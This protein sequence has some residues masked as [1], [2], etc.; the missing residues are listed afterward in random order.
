MKPKFQRAADAAAKTLNAAQAV[1]SSLDGISLGPKQKSELAQFLESFCIELEQ[2]QTQLS[3]SDSDLDL[4]LLIARQLELEEAVRFLDRSFIEPRSNGSNIQILEAADWMCVEGYQLFV[5]ES[6]KYPCGPVVAIDASQSPAVWASSANLPIPSLFKTR[7]KHFDRNET[8]GEFPLICLPQHIARTPEYLPLLSHE[9]GHA[10]DNVL[11]LS[12]QVCSELEGKSNE[13]YW[14]AW[15]REIVGDSVGIALSGEAFGIA[16]RNFLRLQ[17]PFDELAHDHPYPPFE[18]RLKFIAVQLD[19]L[20]NGDLKQDWNLDPAPL[21]RLS[22]LAVELFVQFKQNVV[23]CLDQLIFQRFQSWREDNQTI[24]ELSVALK[25]DSSSAAAPNEMPFRLLPSAVCMAKFT[26][27]P[28][29]EF[30]SREAFRS[31]HGA[32]S[33]RQDLSLIHI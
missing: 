3:S 25:T 30:D 2:K 19:S 28:S 7:P 15:M 22:D 10:V 27:D 32:A 17:P 33:A 31:L 12:T 20:P 6:N 23:G 1:I 8:L 14:N 24:S 9:V 21:E 5:G 16:L 4:Q 18:L 29:G 26:E 13:N 11:G